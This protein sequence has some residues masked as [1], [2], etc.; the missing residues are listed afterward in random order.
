MMGTEINGKFYSGSHA[1]VLS[2]FIRWHL[3]QKDIV[4]G[5]VL[6]N[7]VMLYLDERKKIWK[8]N[9]PATTITVSAPPIRIRDE[10]G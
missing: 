9:D 8:T 6:V 4:H 5:K 10:M 1:D 3:Q 7:Q 2:D